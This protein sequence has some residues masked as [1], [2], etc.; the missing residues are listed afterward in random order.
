ML[1][2]NYDEIDENKKLLNSGE[3][4]RTISSLI[5]GI[6]SHLIK[7]KSCYTEF[8]ATNILLD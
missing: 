7:F 3:F 6:E 5:K 1:I 4:L 2:K 8:V